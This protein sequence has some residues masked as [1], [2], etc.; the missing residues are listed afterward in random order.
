MAM[1][2]QLWK[3]SICRVLALVLAL[4]LILELDHYTNCFQIHL[5]KSLEIDPNNADTLMIRGTIYYFNKQAL[6]DLNR[7]LDI[8]SNN[9][10]NE[11]LEDLNKSLKIIPNNALTLRQRGSIYYNIDEFDK[12]IEV[13][14]RSIEID[15]ATALETYQEALRDL[16]KSLDI[17]PDYTLTLKFRAETYLSIGWYDESIDDLKS[18]LELDPDSAEALSLCSEILKDP[19]K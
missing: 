12:S 13:I 14:N 8:T 9:A 5:N 6:K 17:E 10:I 3:R 11:A 7:S 18:S 15:Y 2:I 16:N 19:L 1:A 4:A